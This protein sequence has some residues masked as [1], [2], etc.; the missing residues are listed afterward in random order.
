MDM[1]VKL[2]QLNLESFRGLAVTQVRKMK[3]YLK[4]N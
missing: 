1:D 4:G 2:N 3:G